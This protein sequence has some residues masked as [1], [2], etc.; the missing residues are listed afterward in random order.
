MSQVNAANLD[1]KSVIKIVK[2]P[3]EVTVTTKQA[4]NIM[5]LIQQVRIT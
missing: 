1:L 2:Q 3:I 4:G 5:K